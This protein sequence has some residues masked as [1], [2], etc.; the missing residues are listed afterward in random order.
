MNSNKGFSMGLR[1]QKLDLQIPIAVRILTFAKKIKW[2]TSQIVVK[3]NK[4]VFN[5]LGLRGACA[6]KKNGCN[7]NKASA[8]KQSENKE[9]KK[10]TKKKMMMKKK[11]EEEESQGYIYKLPIVRFSDCYW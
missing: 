7:T 6:L 3:V 2:E 9:K 10:K 5:L 11:K 1:F 4:K 8:T